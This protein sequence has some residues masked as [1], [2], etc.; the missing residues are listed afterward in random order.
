MKAKTRFT[1][2]FC[3]MTM[4]CGMVLGG[5]T[6]VHAEEVQTAQAI[7][8]KVYAE[9]SSSVKNLLNSV[10]LN[11]EKTGYPLIDDKVE[12]LL[13]Q[14][15]A[16]GANDTYSLVK[17]SYD[18][19]I[20][21]TE[22]GTYDGELLSLQ[23]LF[24]YFSYMAPYMM[25]SVYGVLYGGKGVCDDYTAALIV[26][27]RAIGLEANDYSGQT[28]MAGGGYTGHAWV[29]VPINGV[30]YIFDAQVED[31]VTGS[32]AIN[33][34][35]FCKTEQ[36]MK[37][38]YI[39]GENNPGV[40]VGKER[41][42]AQVEYTVDSISELETLIETQGQGIVGKQIYFTSPA[43]KSEVLSA[44]EA[45]GGEAR[46]KE[47]SLNTFGEV[48][49]LTSDYLIIDSLST[50]FPEKYVGP[51]V[52]VIREGET[53]ELTFENVPE[54]VD[55]S[56]N[57]SG[58]NT[59]DKVAS[60]G[61]V[62]LFI[63]IEKPYGNSSGGRSWFTVEG[64]DGYE[65]KIEILKVYEGETPSQITDENGNAIYS[66]DIAV[67]ASVDV[68]IEGGTDDLENS[69]YS[70]KAIETD[71]ENP[72][73]V[74]YRITGK[75]KGDS[76]FYT[77]DNDGY[78]DNK[79]YVHV[80]EPDGYITL[81]TV[82]YRMAPGNIYDIGVTVKNADGEKL[83][84][85]EVKALVSAGIL[86]VSDS[87]TG[88][89]VNLT[90][91]PNGNFRVTGKTPGTCWITYE[92]MDGSN[93]VTRAS[94]RIDVENGVQQGGVSTRDTSYWQPTILVPAWDIVVTS[95]K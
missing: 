12:E 90:Q 39:W 6:M 28:R 53:A 72:N 83:T 31:N 67:G 9:P 51:E 91:L 47:G 25:P 71:P 32:G 68:W 16:D 73:R 87:R 54:G 56:I 21:N 92:I 94:V 43:N 41:R 66:I 89:V 19:I 57:W 35:Y 7:A 27:F 40:G 5:A 59:V 79:F 85:P 60:N 26:M 36:E 86:K 30:N 58:I 14:F 13:A 84:G 10:K 95:T 76:L 62:S 61:T 50:V 93:A 17:A 24:G 29:E 18:W 23:K 44:V 46:I 4:A 15:K 22:Y 78:V 75:S 20:K 82:N 37:N 70:L 33:Y 3:A 48:E 55:L 81:D 8:P 80:Y 45:M 88:S 1:A 49:F 64:T 69:Y 34:Y 11:P 52:L 38:S 74:K 2:I 65:T 42:L 63:E 77:G